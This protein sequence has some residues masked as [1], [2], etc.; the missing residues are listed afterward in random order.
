MLIESSVC[1]TA[2]GLMHYDGPVDAEA[3][4]LSSRSSVWMQGRPA[5]AGPT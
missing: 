5:N 4:G 3:T 2:I 1:C